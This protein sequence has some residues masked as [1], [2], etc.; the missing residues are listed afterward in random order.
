MAWWTGAEAACWVF[1]DD[2]EVRIRRR[3]KSWGRNRGG[4]GVEEEVGRAAL[5]VY[6][7]FLCSGE[8]VEIDYF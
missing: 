7:V 2:E 6:V 4:V 8:R 3:I 5:F 1:S